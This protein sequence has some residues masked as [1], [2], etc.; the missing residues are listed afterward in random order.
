L[1]ALAAKEFDI[2]DGVLEG[3]HMG[4]VRV[5]GDHSLAVQ[6]YRSDRD[7]AILLVHG[8]GWNHRTWDRI[9]PPL[10]AADYEVVTFD[11]RAC[12]DSDSDFT[13]V[14]IADLSGDVVSVADACGLDRFALMGWS[15]GGAVAVDAAT[16]LGNR[17]TQ[18]VI[19]SGAT[20][21]L[22]QDTDWPVGLPE[23]S[24]PFILQAIHDDRVGFYWQMAKALFF[25]PVD[26]VLVQWAWQQWMQSG[27][28][29]A[30][31]YANLFEIDQR[32]Q[33]AA[34]AVPTLVMHGRHDTFVPYEVAERAV[35]LSRHAT[36]VTFEESGHAP[37]LEESTAFVNALLEFLAV[38]VDV[39]IA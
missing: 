9:V 37:F 22:V 16:R 4:R 33:L 14:S 5:E 21:R 26:E 8:G 11:Q 13:D 2:I 32:A 34:L 28:M 1:N 36:L 29:S 6:H 23:G 3:D 20:P 18:L 7:K 27:V 25:G 12:G 17:V 24:G 39:S 38:R 15:L 30:H 19:A 35:Q 31:S 10:L